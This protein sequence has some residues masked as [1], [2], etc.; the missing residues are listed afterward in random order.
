[1]NKIS[2]EKI[3]ENWPSVVEGDFE[4]PELGFVHYWTGEQRG[5]IVVRFSHEAQTEGESEKMFFVELTKDGWILS[6]ISTFQLQD[7]KLKLIKIQS[8]KEQEE[9][10]KKYR[11]LIE[12]F[13][14]SRDSGKIF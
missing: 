13:I 10:E 7:E 6:H 8:F 5:K 9:L 14:K 11:S 2:E 12:L 4:H 1:M 3:K